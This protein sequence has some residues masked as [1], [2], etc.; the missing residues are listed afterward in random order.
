MLLDEDLFDAAVG[1]LCVREFDGRMD[2]QL[3]FRLHFLLFFTLFLFLLLLSS[4]LRLFL[5]LL[6]P[7]LLLLGFPHLV[8]FHQLFHILIVKRISIVVEF[9]PSARS[10]VT[11]LVIFVI[12]TILVRVFG[13]LELGGSAAMTR[14]V[15]VFLVFF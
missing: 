9:L 15:G 12:I 1:E 3:D 5:S 10:C 8:L 6:L 13:V 2:V 11:S 7:L 14:G 4:F